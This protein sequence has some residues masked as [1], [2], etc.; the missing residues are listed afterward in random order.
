M[1]EIKNG[2]SRFE[3]R[4]GLSNHRR[5]GLANC[6]TWEH[7]AVSLE[8]LVGGDHKTWWN[9]YAE[10][11]GGLEV[12]VHL[13]FRRPL[14]RKIGRFFASQD[15]TGIDAGDMVGLNQAAAITEQSAGGHKVAPMIDCGHRVA[16]GDRRDIYALA[17]E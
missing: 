15:P 6:L 16:D 1:R 14:N 5:G 12:D 4:M 13:H 3:D 11:L 17:V 2:P 7:C 10:C 9:G 8:N